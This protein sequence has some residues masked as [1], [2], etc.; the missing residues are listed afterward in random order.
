MCYGFF[1]EHNSWFF[2]H[3]GNSLEAENEGTGIWGRE[4]TKRVKRYLGCC[5]EYNAR[6]LREQWFLC[7]KRWAS[8]HQARPQFFALHIPEKAPFSTADIARVREIGPCERYFTHLQAMTTPRSH[9]PS[10]WTRG[11]ETR[12]VT[13]PDALQRKMSVWRFTYL[14]PCSPILDVIIRFFALKK[15]QITMNISPG[16]TNTSPHGL[17]PSCPYP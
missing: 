2:A 12:S 9:P 1:V 5:N 16:T 13:A 15:L 17:M 8:R 10:W 11:K 4:R 7:W 3:W 14:P 6:W